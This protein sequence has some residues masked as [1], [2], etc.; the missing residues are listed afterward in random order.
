MHDKK[1]QN[2]KWWSSV[3]KKDRRVKEESEEPTSNPHTPLLSNGAHPRGLV[4]LLAQGLEDTLGR[5]AIG[6]RSN[7]ISSSAVRSQG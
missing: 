1:V 4:T 3:E 7:S 5:Q 2:K 6:I